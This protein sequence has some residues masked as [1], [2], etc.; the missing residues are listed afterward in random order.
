[1][2]TVKNLLKKKVEKLVMKTGN[3]HDYE[4]ASW[5]TKGVVARCS[6]YIYLVE[7]MDEKR[8]YRYVLKYFQVFITFYLSLKGW[9]R[10]SQVHFVKLMSLFRL[11][12]E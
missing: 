3:C 7:E 6:M 4:C 8:N 10:S 2:R 5:E 12:Y 11:R 9:C 1:M